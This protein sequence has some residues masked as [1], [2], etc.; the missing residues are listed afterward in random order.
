[1]KSVDTNFVACDSVGYMIKCLKLFYFD[2]SLLCLL[3]A[4]CDQP[5]YKRVGRD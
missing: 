3:S 2:G 4:V 5:I 1:M